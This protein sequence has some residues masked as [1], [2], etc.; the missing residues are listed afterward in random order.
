MK[1]QKLNHFVLLGIIVCIVSLVGQGCASKKEIW[2]SPETGLILKYKA[3]EKE[4]L[5]YQKLS[6]F[7]QRMDISGQEIEVKALQDFYYSMGQS[8]T[9]DQ[10][11]NCSITIDS[12]DYSISSPRGQMNPDMSPI[13]GESFH[14]DL[15][16]LGYEQNMDEAKTIKYS[17]EG[18]EQSVITIFSALFPQLP[19]Y[20]VKVGD[21][22][23]SVDTVFEESSRGDL[24]LIFQNFNTLVAME[25]VKGLDCVKVDTQ[26]TGTM[27]GGGKQE[28]VTYDYD[29]EIE[30]SGT[31]YFAYK[32]GLLVEERGEGT[33][34]GKLIVPA[35][36][37]SIPMAREFRIEHS[38][39]R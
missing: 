21:S 22:W 7:T 11:I 15:T 18:E 5:S 14:F 2:G 27:S 6:D 1:T 4:R 24:M 31:W 12:V 32:E 33:G 37:M 29:G 3:P 19:D 9:S 10:L 36:D 34:H 38:L 13:I 20:P 26:V 16:S 28:D 23:K 8:N 35:R 39:L 17:I 30:G 25:K